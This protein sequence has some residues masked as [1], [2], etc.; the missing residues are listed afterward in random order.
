VTTA[1]ERRPSGTDTAWLAA[2]KRALDRPLTSYHLV[3]GVSAL[4]LALGMVMVLSASSV[5]SELNHGSPYYVFSRQVMWV[6]VGIPLAWVASQMSLKWIRRMAYPALLFSIGLICL[7]YVPGIGITVNGN[8]NWISVGGP[9][10]LQPSEVAK[11]AI[12]LWAADLYARKDKLLD[13]WRHLL[14]PMIPVTGLVAALVVGEGDLGT[15]LVIF[16]VILGLL[17][18]VGAPTRLFAGAFLAVGGLAI[19]LA[20]TESYRMARLTNFMDPFANFHDSGWQPAHGFFALAQ[21]GWWGVGIGA[22]TEKWRGLPEAHT[23]FIFAVIGEELGLFG[24]LIVLGLF[25]T[26]AYAGIRIA[27]R[28]K[29]CFVRYAAAGITIWLLG[30]AMINIGMVLGLLPVIGIPLPLVSYGGS[31]LLPTLISLGLLLAFAKTEPGARTALRNRRRGWRARLASSL[32]RAR[33]HRGG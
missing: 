3:L 28:T 12:V 31:A 20:S 10:V 27:L 6:A 30:Q 32:G 15:A 2:T 21:G 29:D 22:S 9:F 4:L 18:I 14:V 25:A 1:T 7:T 5:Y 8:R 19:F 26:L 16:A 33:A 17:W 11:L 24:T 23:D 13:Q